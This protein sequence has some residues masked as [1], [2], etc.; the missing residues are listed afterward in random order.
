MACCCTRIKNLCNVP[1]CGDAAVINTGVDATA[2]GIYTLVLQFLNVEFRIGANGVTGEELVFPAHELNEN[3]T[4]TGKIIGPD[5]QVVTFQEGE[6]PNVVTYDCISF[7]T[8]LSY[9]VSVPEEEPEP[10][11]E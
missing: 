3:Y 7:K 9:V 11:N 1:V 8:M 6:E 4:F 2:D 5:G 10:P